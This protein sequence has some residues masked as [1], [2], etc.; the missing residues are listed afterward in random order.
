MTTRLSRKA[1]DLASEFSGN[2]DAAIR[3]QASYLAESEGREFADENDVRKATAQCAFGLVNSIAAKSQL[4]C[5]HEWIG[6]SLEGY[7][8]TKCPAVAGKYCNVC[9][10]P[11]EGN[12]MGPCWKCQ[13]K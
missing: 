11:M 10:E 4:Q 1:Q 7:R 13:S 2:F 12:L 5:E 3:A 6:G 9:H 8:C